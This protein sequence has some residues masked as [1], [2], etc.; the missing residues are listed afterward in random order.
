VYIDYF[1][2]RNYPPEGV[3]TLKYWEDLSGQMILRAMP[4]GSAATGRASLA[5]KVK[6]DA[7]DEER[8]PGPPEQGVGRAAGDRTLEK[9]TLL[10]RLKRIIQVDVK[11]GRLKCEKDYDLR[12]KIRSW[13]VRTMVQQVK[14]QRLQ[15][16]YRNMT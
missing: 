11:K 14:W 2:A 7:T 4:G 3:S 13:N 12:M 5:G 6:G 1:S 10:R 15:T 9:S 16:N 8:H